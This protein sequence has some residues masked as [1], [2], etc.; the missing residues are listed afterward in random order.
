MIRTTLSTHIRA[1][2]ERVF[3]LYWD[4]ANWPRIF[5]TIRAVRIVRESGDEKAV[6]VEHAFEGAVPNLVRRRSSTRIDL[7][8]RKPRYDATFANLFEPE[9]DGTRYTLV[10]EVRLKGWNRLAAPLVKPLVRSRMRRF[11]LEAIKAAAEK[12]A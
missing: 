3:A 6:E 8:E 7:E 2:A 4:P 1:P 11:V 5:P 10:A 9:A 12:N